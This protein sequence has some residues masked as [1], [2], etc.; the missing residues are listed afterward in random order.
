MDKTP[1][2]VQK[3]GFLSLSATVALSLS[4]AL[5]DAEETGKTTPL[6]TWKT[7][8]LRKGDGEERIFKDAE[9]LQKMKAL[10]D[11]YKA[12]RHAP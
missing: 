8:W 6:S 7:K 2:T 1:K 5:S 4:R 11:I 9:Y 3:D 12:Y 10:A